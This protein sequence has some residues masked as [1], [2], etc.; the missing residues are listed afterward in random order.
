MYDIND[1]LPQNR[2][3]AKEIMIDNDP[4]EKTKN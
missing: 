2:Y 1:A 3:N 4:Y